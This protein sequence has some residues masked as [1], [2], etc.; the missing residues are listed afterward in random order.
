MSTLVEQTGESPT[1]RAGRDLT[2]WSVL[3]ALLLL[4]ALAGPFFAGRI[5]TADDLGAPKKL[6][7]RMCDV[8]PGIAKLVNSLQKT[9]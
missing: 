8:Q 5:Y 7:V 9:E 3:A 1:R 2:A 6:P 4:G